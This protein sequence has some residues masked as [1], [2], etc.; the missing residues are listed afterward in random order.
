MTTEAEQAC[1]IPQP[2]L[3]PA[4]I[5]DELQAFIDRG[6]DARWVRAMGHAPGVL[7]AWTT[8]YWPLLFGGAVEMRTKELTRLRIAALNGCHY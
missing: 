6:V 7:T 1:P 3:P 2:L 5:T 8:F 4:P